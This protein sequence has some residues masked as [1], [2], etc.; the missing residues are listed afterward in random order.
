MRL[1]H[2]EVEE[3]PR[4]SNSFLRSTVTFLLSSVF[5][6]LSSV[7]WATTDLSSMGN[8]YM[9]PRDHVV[10]LAPR[11]MG[12][13][14]TSPFARRVSRVLVALLSSPVSNQRPVLY[15]K[16]C[17]LT[18]FD[19]YHFPPTLES[20]VCFRRFHQFHISR[21]ENWLQYQGVSRGCSSC[22]T[23]TK[24]RHTLRA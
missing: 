10:V 17:F 20:F 2:N 3:H 16:L 12:S 4:K 22:S 15:I 21:I 1:R 6:L 23:V 14:K 18:F 5:C 13:I 11:S 24:V 8:G 19:F 9:H 7:A